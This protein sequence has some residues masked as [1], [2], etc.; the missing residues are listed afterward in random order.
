MSKKG[1]VFYGKK[2][3]GIISETDEGYVFL[4]DKTYLSSDNAK[5]VSLTMPLTDGAYLSKVLFAFFDGLIPE[6]W[7]LDIATTH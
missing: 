1:K 6:G 4:Y 3:A 7:L 2:L 5:P